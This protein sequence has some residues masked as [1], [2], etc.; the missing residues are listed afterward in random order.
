MNVVAR[1]KKALHD[2]EVLERFETGIVLEGSEVKSIRAGTI[3]LVDC[4]AMASNGELFVHHM[5]I[6]PYGQS[7]AYAPDPYRRR[8][9]LVHKKQVAKL[10]E[11]VSKKGLSLIPLS[12]YIKEQWVKVELGLCKGRKQ[13]DKRQKLATQDVKRKIDQLIKNQ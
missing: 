6:T 8:K 5:H 12:L 9:L 3:N 11:S 1:N 10:A 2:Y 13:F 7:K 4:Y